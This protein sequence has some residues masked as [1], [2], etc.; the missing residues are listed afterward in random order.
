MA[1]EMD[2]I[3][4]FDKRSFVIFTEWS[5]AYGTAL[6]K[7]LIDPWKRKDKS[8]SGVDLGTLANV[9]LELAFFPKKDIPILPLE[10]LDIGPTPVALLRNENQI[11]FFSELF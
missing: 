1:L 3:N 10:F 4:T 6:E 7:R 11:I 9:I 2:E 8:I 5:A